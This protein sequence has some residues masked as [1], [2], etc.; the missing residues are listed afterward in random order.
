MSKLNETIQSCMESDHFE[1]EDSSNTSTEEKES[2]S[3]QSIS[4]IRKMIDCE[5]G[6]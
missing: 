2:E 3:A 5:E 4:N 6:S 1:K